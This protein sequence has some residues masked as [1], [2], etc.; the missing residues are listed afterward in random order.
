M[1]YFGA[2]DDKRL[3]RLQKQLTKQD[4]LI[5]DKLGY[6]PLAKTGSELLFEM[7]ESRSRPKAVCFGVC[8]S[9]ASCCSWA[10]SPCS[11]TSG[12]PALIE[13]G[14]GLCQSAQLIP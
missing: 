2:R 4:L 6:V 10:I 9:T 13:I 3:L 11:L 12:N 7:T 14:E 1:S 8:S 5:V